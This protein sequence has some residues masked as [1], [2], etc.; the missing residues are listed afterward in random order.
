MQLH[1]DWTLLVTNIPSGEDVWREVALPWEEVAPG[2]LLDHSN[3]LKVTQAAFAGCHSVSA[4][5]SHNAADLSWVDSEV[6]DSV[7]RRL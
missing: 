3:D 7:W 2:A 6:T 1:K 5:G 4:A